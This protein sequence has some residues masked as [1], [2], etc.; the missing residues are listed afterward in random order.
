[1]CNFALKT[2]LS[3]FDPISLITHKLRDR[4]EV[5]KSAST[6]G[7]EV[8]Y[9]IESSFRGMTNSYGERVK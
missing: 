4:T 9:T 7:V 8:S 3:C 1:M 5:L 2:W 6:D